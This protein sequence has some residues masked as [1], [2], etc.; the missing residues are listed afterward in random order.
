VTI[1]RRP[2]RAALLGAAFGAWIWGWT[3]LLGRAA[4]A[5]RDPALAERV[6]ALAS[7]EAF[8][9]SVAERFGLPAPVG[10][11][12][13]LGL[14]LVGALLGVGASLLVRALRLDRDD[15]AGESM[16]WS[17]GWS[18]PMAWLF[19]FGLVVA[20]AVVVPI[21]DGVA[22]ALLVLTVPLLL[23]AL[24]AVTSPRYAAGVETRWWRPVWPGGK[25][26]V[27]WVLVQAAAALLLFGLALASEDASWRRVAL[28]LVGFWIALYAGALGFHALVERLPPSRLA[29]RAAKLLRP[30]ALG[31]WL[32]LGARQALL[33]AFFS[34][35]L[36]AALA[37]QWRVAPALLQWEHGSG[38]EIALELRW[39]TNGLGFVERFAV[40]F[41]EPAFVL[42]FWGQ[43]ARLV[44]RVA[45]SSFGTRP[46][47]RSGSVPEL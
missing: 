11:D 25:V 28:V 26:L 38:R 4:V 10:W 31:P 19:L 14:A 36:L 16:R 21:P 17:Q 32:V 3:E 29:T 27:A 40:Y 6:P 46:P 42:L 47:S 8:V 15:L 13:A 39:A 18:A 9:R 20:G 37:W 24:S 30:S 44:Y 23:V 2:R 7:P 33:L 22:V 1:D 45:S 34:I 35:P 12:W 41:L 43:A 5:W